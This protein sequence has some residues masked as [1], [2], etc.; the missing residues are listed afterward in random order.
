MYADVAYWI[1]TAITP[2]VKYSSNADFQQP[3]DSVLRLLDN[4]E[5]AHHAQQLAYDKAKAALHSEEP[6]A[7]ANKRRLA[8]ALAAPKRRRIEEE[9]AQLVSAAAQRRRL[10][11][12]IW[13]V[14]GSRRRD[15]ITHPSPPAA[16]S[17]VP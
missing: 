9:E 17:R 3:L 7:L 11:E 2:P 4:T 16:A 1:F 5:A 8:E 13:T 10:V 15:A 12:L 6:A 14:S